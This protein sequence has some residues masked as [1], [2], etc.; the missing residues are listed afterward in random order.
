MDIQLG[1]EWVYACPQ[2][3]PMILTLEVHYD[4]VC[5]LAL[6]PDLRVAPSFRDIVGQQR[7]KEE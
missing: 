1:C 4:R 3:T 2:Q 7:D 6:K 5:D